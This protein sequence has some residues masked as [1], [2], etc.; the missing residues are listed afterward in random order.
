[1]THSCRYQHTL[2]LTLL[3]GQTMLFFSALDQLSA[4]IFKFH[5]DIDDRARLWG[6]C[7]YQARNLTTLNFRRA[8]KFELVSSSLGPSSCPGGVYLSVI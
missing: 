5:L 7:H 3:G 6:Y 2:S 8:R 4:L 1:M